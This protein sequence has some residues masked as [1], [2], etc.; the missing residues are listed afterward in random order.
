MTI[1]KII[2][3]YE[4]KYFLSKDS[5]NIIMMKI[6]LTLFVLF[7]SFSV[8]AGCISGNCTNGYGTYT[9][10]DGDI[11]VGKFKDDKLEGQGTLTLANGDVG[12]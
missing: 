5:S 12:K 7:A 11:Y 6:F 4:N 1:F 3:S 9:F 8:F 2:L 10:T